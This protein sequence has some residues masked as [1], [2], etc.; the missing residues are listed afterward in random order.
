MSCIEELFLT[1]GQAAAILAVNPLTVQRWVKSGR[2]AGH[3]VGHITLL[4]RQ[5]VEEIARQRASCYNEKGSC[6]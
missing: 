6:E 1:S 5:E 4:S 3:K 2:L